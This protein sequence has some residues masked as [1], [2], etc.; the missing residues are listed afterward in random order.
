[1]NCSTSNE[2]QYTGWSH[3]LPFISSLQRR[4]NDRVRLLPAR[5]ILRQAYPELCRRALPWRAR[6]RE[7]FSADPFVLV[8]PL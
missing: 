3:P 8:C 2:K 6:E 1:M 4:G 5:S 7:R